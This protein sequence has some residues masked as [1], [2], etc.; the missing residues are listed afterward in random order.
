MDRAVAT[1]VSG[2]VR[3]VTLR[4]LI[5]LFHVALPLLGLALLLGY[6]PLDVVLEDHTAHFWVVLG[7]ALISLA[8][9]ILV[10]VAAHRNDDARLYLTALGFVASAGFLGLHAFVTP[11]VVI[12]T[13]SVAFNFATP[14]GLVLAAVFA[15]WASLDHSDPVSRV[16]VGRRALLAAVV[17]AALLAWAVLSIV[18]GSPLLAPVPP[19]ALRP[20]LRALAVVG[21]ALFTFAGIRLFL[22]YRSKPSV[23]LLSL[24]TTVVLLGEALVA[25]AEAPNWHLSWWEWHILMAIGFAYIAYAAHVEYRREGTTTTL[26]A[27]ISSD[28]TVRRIREGYAEALTS[29]VAAI[30]SSG[31]SDTAAARRAAIDRIRDEV[32]LSAGQAEVLEQAATSLAEERM[33]T[34]RL[35]AI[36]DI[37]RESRVGA[38]DASLIVTALT[39]LRDA[40]QGDRLAVIAGPIVAEGADVV[41]ETSGGPSDAAS[42]S[43]AT[44]RS[45]GETSRQEDGDGEVV[46]IPLRGTSEPSRVL[47]AERA[48]GAFSERAVATLETAGAQ[49]AAQLENARLYRQ[50]DRLFRAYL[51][52][53]VARA[54]LEDPGRARLGGA[55]ADLTVLF[56]DLR[57]YT[58]FSEARDAAAVVDLLNRYFGAIVPIVLAEGGT[59][60]QFAGDAIMAIWGAPTAD[61]RHAERASRAALQIRRRIDDLAERHPDWPR[62]RFGLATGTAVVG[63]VGAAEVRTF[64]A[65]GETTNLAARLQTYAQPGSIVVDAATAEALGP[66]A[67]L[68]PLGDLDLR[69][70]AGPIA[71]FELV[72]LGEADDR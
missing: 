10:L 41:S 71:A 25:I 53:D 17:A 35:G 55:H 69:G 24:L 8:L 62:F 2:P 31:T 60:A 38:D 57:G 22:R 4:P 21:I 46:A 54:L 61:E 15:A 12:A 20:S 32:G 70:F 39:G 64:T 13:P 72:D 63:N 58:S 49:L 44:A 9:A 19:E 26:F 18:P 36:V 5:W 59:V 65:T 33:Q 42:R 47:L 27:G 66:A 34:R 7:T 52:P 67:K 50:V 14:V 48:T 40:F 37:G 3:R 43:V 23:V 30:E 6:P 28:E 45:T 56:A 1:T 68:R 16:I 51:S 11:A 29:L